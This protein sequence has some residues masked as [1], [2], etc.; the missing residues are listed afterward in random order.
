M[1]AAA[2]LSTSSA[3]FARLA[4][5]SIRVRVDRLGRPALVLEEDRQAEILHVAGKGTARLAARALAAV[6]QVERQA[7]DDALHLLLADQ[8]GERG[9]VLLELGAADQ[10]GRGAGEAPTGVAQRGADR[11]GADVEAR[12]GG[13]RAGRASRKIGHGRW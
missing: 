12:S 9:L 8:R 4:S 11:L 1:Y 2:I 5:C 10:Q 6:G 13:P 7:D 3:R